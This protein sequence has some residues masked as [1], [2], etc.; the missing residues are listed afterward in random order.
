MKR[1][2]V[3]F[4]CI[5]MFP[6]L[7]F[8]ADGSNAEKVVRFQ[9]VQ[10][11]HFFANAQGQDDTTS[12]ILRYKRFPL[13]DKAIPN[14]ENLYI[15]MEF[16]SWMNELLKSEYVPSHEF[17]AENLRLYP[18]NDAGRKEDVAILAFDLPGK[19]F[20]IAQT[21]A[22]D[23]FWFYARDNTLPD[24]QEK[25]EANLRAQRA[26]S[27]YIREDYQPHI[28]ELEL[29]DKKTLFAGEPKSHRIEQNKNYAFCAG[30]GKD[31]CLLLEKTS[32]TRTA[33]AWT[34]PPVP[35]L[36]ELDKRQGD[37]RDWRQFTRRW[38]HGRRETGSKAVFGG[39]QGS[40]RQAACVRRRNGVVHL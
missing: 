12:L 28:P 38:D 39:G 40:S 29:L 32:Y 11:A 18:A 27:E 25:Q 30:M 23:K 19:R 35:L 17:V 24:V 1:F 37:V 26:V 10:E 7:G 3:T 34:P 5:N 16:Q 21:G 33:A 31:V 20:L 13:K 15:V 6:A 2:I 14:A 4:C 9:P 22:W 8:G 36:L